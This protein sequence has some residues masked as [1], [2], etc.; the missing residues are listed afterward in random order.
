MAQGSEASYPLIPRSSGVMARLT[1]SAMGRASQDPSI[2]REPDVH[3]ALLIRGLS[4]MVA[5]LAPLQQDLDDL[6]G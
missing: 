6:R 5:C 4:V 1:L 2:W 3:R